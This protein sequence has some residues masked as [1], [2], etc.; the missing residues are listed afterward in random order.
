[1][2]KIQFQWVREYYFTAKF[3][4]K[5]KKKGLK[6]IRENKT[7]YLLTY[8]SNKIF[9]NQFEPAS[10]I[11]QK[12]WEKFGFIWLTTKSIYNGDRTNSIQT[13]HVWPSQKNCSLLL[14]FPFKSTLSTKQ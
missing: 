8:P 3:K 14:A 1:M 4:K 12:L 5:K 6:S 13:K 7:G 2:N 10:P 11:F 9:I